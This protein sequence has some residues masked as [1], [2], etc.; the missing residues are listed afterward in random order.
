MIKILTRINDISEE[1]IV[2]TIESIKK[3]GI[4]LFGEPVKWV[5]N[6]LDSSGNALKGQ[7]LYVD[8]IYINLIQRAGIIAFAYLT[9]ILTVAMIKTAKAKDYWFLV[10]F[11]IVLFSILVHQYCMFILILIES[12]TSCIC[13]GSCICL[14]C[15]A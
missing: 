5:G 10:I 6:G 13:S 9:A 3:F 14:I 1:R 12:G 2:L 11:F 7:Y 4:S 15:I 8:N